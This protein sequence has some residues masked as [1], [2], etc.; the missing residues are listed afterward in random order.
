MRFSLEECEEATENRFLRGLKTEI[1]DTLLHETYNSLSCLIKLASKIENKLTLSEEKIVELSLTCEKENCIDVMSFV[2]C[3]AMINIE[4]NRMDLVERPMKEEL[5]KGQ[6]ICSYIN[7]AIEEMHSINI[8]PCESSVLVL[9]L[10]T[11]PA[12]LEKLLVEP[13]AVFPLLHDDYMIV[14]CDREELRD[15]ASLISLPQLVHGHESSIINDQH[16]EV[17]RVHCINS[18]EDKLQIISSLNCLGYIKFNLSY[19]LNSFEDELFWKSGLQYLDYYTFHALGLFDN[20]NGYIVQ[21][22]YIHSD[23]TSFM[24]PISDQ[25]VTYIEANNTISSFSPIDDTLQVNFKEREPFL[26]HCPSVN[27]LDLC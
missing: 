21:K 25:K 16:A 3:S 22:V 6:S 2:V 1:Q 4:Q 19:D 20:N 13:L 7:P 12:S 8:T 15:H 5:E 14:P 10:S 24:V 23:L 18:E 17:R 9:N 11:T 26:L 27:I